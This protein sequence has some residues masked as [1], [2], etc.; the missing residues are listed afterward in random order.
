M[1]LSLQDV[2]QSCQRTNGEFTKIK[3]PS[4]VKVKVKHINN[5][6]HH[7]LAITLEQEV[8]ET[9]GWFP[10]VPYRIVLL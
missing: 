6:E 4:T 2:H 5:H 8:I 3:C 10:N 7:I 9:S 1:N